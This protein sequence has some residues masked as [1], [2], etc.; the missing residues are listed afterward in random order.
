VNEELRSFLLGTAVLDV[1]VVTA[2]LLTLARGAIDRRPAL[3]RPA[4]RLSLFALASQAAHFAEELAT[5]LHVRFPE[6]LGL[7]AWP[8]GLFVS[9]NLLWLAIWGVSIAPLAAGHRWALFPVWFLALGCAVNGVL[10]PVAAI[11][12]AGYF[13]G[14]VTS[15]LSGVVGVLLL[16]RLRLVTRG[17]P[18]AGLPAR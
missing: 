13:P 4:V 8:L 14:L 2:A 16:R 7:P 3:L 12:V 10:H 18:S 1:L 11:V 9:F 15:P 17:S 5:G 6:L